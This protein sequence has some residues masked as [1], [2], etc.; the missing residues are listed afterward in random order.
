M[1]GGSTDGTNNVQRAGV[2]KLASV[3]ERYYEE[4][5]KRVEKGLGIVAKD[6][7]G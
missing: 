2:A 4:N 6:L 1:S 7:C 5:L 3:D